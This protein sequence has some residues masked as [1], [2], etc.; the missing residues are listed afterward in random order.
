[1]TVTLTHRYEIKQGPEGMYVPN[2]TSVRVQSADDVQTIIS[3]GAK[4]RA[5]GTTNMNE[6]SSRSHA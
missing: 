4:N 5:T 3:L 1:M 6:H 2:L